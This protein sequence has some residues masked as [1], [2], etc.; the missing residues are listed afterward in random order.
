MTAPT[1]FVALMPWVFVWVWSTGF[2]VAKFGQPYAEPFTLLS[3][4]FACAM[5]VLLLIMPLFKTKWSNNPRLWL[6]SMIVGL[7]I[8]GVY[9]GGVFQ[10]IALGM[11]AGMSSM[12]IGLQ[13]L[14]MA[15]L[16]GLMLK[17]RVTPWQWLGLAIGLVGLYLVLA[18][19]FAIDAKQLF[20]GFSGWSA[21]LVVASLM[22]ISVGSTYQKKYCQGIDLLAS[23]WWQYFAA[24]IF[25]VFIALAFEERVVD[26]QW[27]FVLSL[28]WQVLALSIGA[29]LLLM[30]MINL[31]ESARVA[32]LFYLVPPVV[33][34]QAWWWF[35]EELGVQ[36]LLGVA[37]IACGVALAR[38]KTTLKA[39]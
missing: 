5:L 25:C 12:V 28:S 31:G 27:A 10:A 19:R 13:P 24:T 1:W 35:G 38:R 26:W 29:I 6:H 17:E 22:G 4:R 7:L 11:P 2:L 23:I 21:V 15:L 3:I 39:A 9:L 37:L 32:S 33:A 36:A 16:A 34:I 14:V 20:D 18:E 8:H 30:L